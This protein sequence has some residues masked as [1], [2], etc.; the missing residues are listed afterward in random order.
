M[1]RTPFFL[2]FVPLALVACGSEA[3]DT[4]EQPVVDP[5]AAPG[6]QVGVVVSP[7]DGDV[8]P[9][10]VTLDDGATTALD[11]LR[12]ARDDLT[13]F[14]AGFGIAVCAIGATGCAADACFG[15]PTCPDNPAQ[16]LFW[17]FFTAGP[18]GDWKIAELGADQTAVKD[19]DRVAFLWSGFDASYEPL[20]RPP[21]LTLAEIAGE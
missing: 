3:V 8:E 13:T 19:G 11:A 16:E 21:D 5:A 2:F 12:A 4:T 18:T 17:A 9:R 14:D 7:S 20:R 15:G 6:I 10:L 1:N